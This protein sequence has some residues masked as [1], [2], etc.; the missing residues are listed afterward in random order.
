MKII[1]FRIEN[2]KGFL[3]SGVVQLG[4]GFN[5]FVGQNDAGKTALL[6]A[7]T[8]QNNN[9]PHRSLA[10][11]PYPTSAIGTTST[12]LR[13][14]A[15]KVALIDAISGNGGY[16]GLNGVVDLPVAIK[17]VTDWLKHP[18][19]DVNRT[20]NGQYANSFPP[21]EG[22]PQ[23]LSSEQVR[24]INLK[25]A[26]QP[27]GYQLATQHYSNEGPHIP[28]QLVAQF[29]SRL[30][31]FLPERFNLGQV[32]ARGRLA[33]ETN[34][35]NLAEVLN[36]LISSNPHRFGRL[37]GYVRKVFPHITNITAPLIQDTDMAEILVHTEDPKLERSD[38]AIPL[39][40][41]GTGVGQVLALLYQVIQ[42]DRP[43]I[44]CIDEPQSFLHPGAFRKLLEILRQHPQHQYLICTHS[45]AGLGATADD[46]LFLVKRTLYGSKV[47]PLPIAD[48]N[49]MRDVLAEVGARLSDVF[50]ADSMLW[51]EGKTEEH[52]LPEVL[53]RFEPDALIGL[54]VLGVIN[55]GELTGKHAERFCE[56][57]CRLTACGALMP[58]TVAFVLDREGLNESKR[59]EIEHR[60]G[61]RAR[62]L[63]RRM[64]ECYLLDCESIAEILRKI[65]PDCS[66]D[67]EAVRTWINQNGANEKYLASTHQV[68][69]NEWLEEVDAANL[70]SDLWKSLT[71]ARHDYRKVKDG[72]DLTRACL[73]K[74]DAGLKSLAGQMAEWI[75]TANLAR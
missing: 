54:Q 22:W 14:L 64:Y 49:T 2:F 20:A 18:E 66:H 61:Q 24:A 67:V 72:L 39:S 25:A 53:R 50:G 23:P 21:Q 29:V 4:A 13:F 45:P 36:K 51:V 28:D 70:L 5:F 33:L 57:Y 11:A 32:Q 27:V 63:P 7:L 75:R 38:L 73:E 60:L 48:Q 58:P 16:L 59:K 6:R 17:V 10:T 12:K 56:I 62:W 55:T 44:I 65:D 15:D 1:E 3:D 40:Q 19:V 43:S 46:R 8:L 71:D 52:C 26:P 68:F 69:S 31:V 42:S 34:A 30:Y 41:S 74:G 35:R 37:L 47:M 9:E